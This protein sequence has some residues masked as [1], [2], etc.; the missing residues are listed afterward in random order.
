MNPPALLLAVV[1]ALS[2]PVALAE[3]PLQ[4]T[5]RSVHDGDSMRVQCPGKRGTVAVRMHQIDAPELEQAHGV[6][7]RDQLRQLCRVGSTATIHTQGRDQYG[8][9]LGDVCC[10]DTSVN[11]AMVASG[12]AW[13]Y[14]RYVVDRRLYQLQDAAR[15][16]RRGL[17]AG[18]SPQAPWRWRYENRR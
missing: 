6:A 18:R 7:A 11:E 3:A 4:C 10:G 16:A 5:V 12:A 1:A 2:A 17:W 15:A 8:R 9:L 14:N 13:V